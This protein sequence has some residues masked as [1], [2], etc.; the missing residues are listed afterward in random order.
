MRCPETGKTLVKPPREILTG[1][2]ILRNLQKKIK[3]ICVTTNNHLK[4]KLLNG[5][6]LEGSFKLTFPY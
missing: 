3:N 2:H 5:Y 6:R 1:Q 4:K